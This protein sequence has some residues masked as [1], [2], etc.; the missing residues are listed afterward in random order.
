MPIPI[1]IKPGQG[2]ECIVAIDNTGAQDHYFD[3]GFVVYR[4]VDTS[5]D[6]A[7]WGMKED[8]LVHAG[9][10][11]HIVHIYSEVAAPN[12]PGDYNLVITLGDYSKEKGDWIQVYDERQI[13]N[14]VTISSG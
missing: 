4:V 2:L 5:I 12:R 14:A 8:E 10:Y 7:L 13:T 1:T 6:I 9:E 3:I 11:D